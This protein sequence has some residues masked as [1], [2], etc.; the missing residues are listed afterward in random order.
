MANN[1]FSVRV[2]TGNFRKYSENVKAA[3]TQ[4]LN[5]CI[6]DLV[7]TSSQSA[8]HDEGI[9]EQSWAKEIQNSNGGPVGR[10]SFSV[11]ESSSGGNFNY[12][13]KMHEG[14]YKLGPNSQSKPGGVGMSGTQYP[15]GPGY[16]GN[17][18]KGEANAY[19]E[20][21]KKEILRAGI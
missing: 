15:V 10:V 7:R 20:H 8:P 13:L 14:R 16:L 3:Y 1:G 9:L 19:K 11:R 21:I 12:A 6:D 4:A 2:N 17:V 18:L 5:D